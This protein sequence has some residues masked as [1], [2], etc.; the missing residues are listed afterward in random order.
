MSI[1][2]KTTI[3]SI[4]SIIEFDDCFGSVGSGMR[5]AMYNP[6]VIVN[7]AIVGV[8]TVLYVLFGAVMNIL[9]L[10][11][12][13]SGDPGDSRSPTSLYLTHLALVDL[14]FVM[15]YLHHFFR[16]YFSSFLPPSFMKSICYWMETSRVLNMCDKGSNIF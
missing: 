16:M 15:S 1:I 11:V 13:C 14:I 12:L 6:A 3:S 10:L 9:I 5:L 8:F 7:E 4:D 2:L